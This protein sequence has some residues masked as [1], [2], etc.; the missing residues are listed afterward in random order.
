[1]ISTDDPV[2]IRMVIRSYRNTKKRLILEF[3]ENMVRSEPYKNID[4]LDKELTAKLVSLTGNDD[5]HTPE[6]WR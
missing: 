1:M 6:A 2:A 4:A 5:C 3:G